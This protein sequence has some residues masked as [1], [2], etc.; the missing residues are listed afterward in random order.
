MSFG[1]FISGGGGVGKAKV[2]STTDS[3]KLGQDAGKLF[4]ADDDDNIAIGSNALASTTTNSDNNIAIGTS[5]LGAVTTGDSNVGIGK[6]AGDAIT[7]GGYNIAFGE[8]ALSAV[9]GNSYNVAIGYQALLVSNDGSEAGNASYNIAIGY[10]AGKSITTSIKGI[11]IGNGAGDELSGAAN[12]IIVIGDSAFPGG[13]DTGGATS[14]IIALGKQAMGTASV[15]TAHN[16]S[17][18][19]GYRALFGGS[20]A[21]Q[22]TTS[23]NIA[24]GWRSMY[25]MYSGTGNTG[26]GYESLKAQATGNYNTAIGYRASLVNATGNYNTLIGNQC[27]TDVATESYRTYLGHRGMVRYITAEVTL[28]AAHTADNTIIAEIAKIP[29][30]SIIKSVRAEIVTLS[31][32]DPYIVNLS[33]STTTGSAADAALANAGSSITVPEILGAGAANTY[34]RNSGVAMAGTAADIKV[35]SDGVLKTIYYNEPTTT[36]VGTNDVYLYA[37][38]AGNNGTTSATTSAVLYVTVEY[39]GKD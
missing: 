5:A 35:A 37:C 38:N 28:T 29:A 10:Q 6:S 16:N 17:I 30:L 36:I 22:Q 13:D 2:D 39:I 3:I 4:N 25:D 18:A 20:G 27:D 12:D 7:T 24:I 11:L 23:A 33:L 9:T 8:D 21:P 19:I 32:L 31:N 1:G 15:G 34:Q 14:H 26:I